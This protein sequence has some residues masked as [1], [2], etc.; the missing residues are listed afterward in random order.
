MFRH[1]MV[2]RPNGRFLTQRQE[3][4]M[5]HISVAVTDQGIELTAPGT[6]VLKLPKEIHVTKKNVMSV[7]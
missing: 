1:W 5:A 2:V 4:K 6:K 7:G 3:P